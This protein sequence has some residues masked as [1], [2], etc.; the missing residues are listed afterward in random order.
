MH[1]TEIFNY[2]IKIL[3]M[4]KRR[5]TALKSWIEVKDFWLHIINVPELILKSFL[6][7]NRLQTYVTFM[8]VYYLSI[9]QL[10][11]RDP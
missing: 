11:P 4:Q 1:K 9:F 10:D 3:Q 7:T 8:M 6:L 2:V 5:Y